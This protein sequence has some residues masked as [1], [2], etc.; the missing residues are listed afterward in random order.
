MPL[1]EPIIRFGGSPTSVATPPVSDSRAA[2][3]RNG[4]GLIPS[5]RA[6][7]MISGPKITTVVTLSS[8]NDSTVT[9]LPSRNKSVN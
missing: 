2:A 6:M 5:E 7:K 9:A 3:S 8:N 4:M 1:A